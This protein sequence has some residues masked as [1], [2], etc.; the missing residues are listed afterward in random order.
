MRK[1]AIHD[2]YCT[3]Q[4]GTTL[5]E[6]LVSLLIFSVGLLGMAGLHAA[7]LRHTHSGYLRT[8]ATLMAADISERM[9]SNAEGL[10]SGAYRGA[11]GALNASCLSATGC[12]AALMALHDIAEWRIDLAAALPAGDGIVC[13]DSTPVDGTPVA[14]ACDGIGDYYAVKVWWSDN[15]EGSTAQRYA[16]TVP[17]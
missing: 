1:A 6:V 15:R 9:R 11:A 14:P 4:S 16:V 8:Y 10:R 7:S 2:P 17:L 3:K 12:S 13:I 5:I